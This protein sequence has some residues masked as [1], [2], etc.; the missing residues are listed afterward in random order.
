MNPLYLNPALTGDFDGQWRFNLNQRSQWRS[1]SRP[2]NTVA[3]SADNREGLLLPGM[4]H[5]L[6]FMHDVAGDGNYR[7]TEIG[8]S[9]AYQLYLGADSVHSF[10]PAVHLAFNHRTIDFSKLSFDNQ[11]NGYYYDP[12]LPTNEVFGTNSRAGFNVSVGGIYSWKPDEKKEVVV[13]AGLFNIPQIKQSFYGDDGI[14]RDRR[15]LVHAR[16]TLPLKEKWDLQPALF[17]Q[18]Q[19]KYTELVLGTNI[20]YTLK[21]R[22]NDYFAPYAGIY[23]R[24]KDGIYIVAGAYYNDWIVG[25]SYDVNT[26]DLTP[27]SRVRGGLEFSVQ[28]ILRLFKPKVIQYRVCPDYL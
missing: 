19:G 18:F 10:T 24:N 1:V 13:G 8:L 2:Y 15:V 28:Y 9:T 23:F 4:Y 25:V 6:N 5:G 26:S 22:R 12:S 20:R 17:G 11:F 16:A 7:T 27:A 21:E 14:K 3:I